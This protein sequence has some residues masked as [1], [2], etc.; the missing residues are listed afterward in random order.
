MR[1]RHGGKERR[2]G[3]EE[4]GKREGWRFEGRQGDHAS[5]ALLSGKYHL[6]VLQMRLQLLVFEMHLIHFV[7]SFTHSVLARVCSKYKRQK[8]QQ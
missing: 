2:K 1:R 7:L 5:A 8:Q 4:G 6:G 3:R